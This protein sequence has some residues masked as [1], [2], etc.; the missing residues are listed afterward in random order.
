M[1]SGSRMSQT[2]V[3]SSTQ[4]QGSLF[5]TKGP[6]NNQNRQMNRDRPFRSSSDDNV[7][8]GNYPELLKL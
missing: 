4:S 7:D 8:N 3:S 1:D 6:R 2:S 5:I